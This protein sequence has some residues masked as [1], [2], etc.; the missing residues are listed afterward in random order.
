MRK[1]GDPERSKRLTGE[2]KIYVFRGCKS[3]N[4]GTDHI[5]ILESR[6]KL[7]ESSFVIHST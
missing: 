6:E 2:T 1:Y 4:Q 7:V 5:E 3:I